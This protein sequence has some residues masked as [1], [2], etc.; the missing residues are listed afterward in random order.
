[1]NVTFPCFLIVEWKREESRK[2]KILGCQFLEKEKERR[3]VEK[4]IPERELGAKQKSVGKYMGNRLPFH[5]VL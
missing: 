5:D 3:K 4:E 1:M 2:M